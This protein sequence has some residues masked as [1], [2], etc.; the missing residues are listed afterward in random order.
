MA[1]PKFTRGTIL[2][3]TPHYQLQSI[4]AEPIRAE[5]IGESYRDDRKVKYLLKL[6]LSDAVRRPASIEITHTQCL[7]RTA[8]GTTRVFIEEEGDTLNQDYQP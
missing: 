3:L 2:P 1:L 8:T 6:H 7:L 5:V 4:G